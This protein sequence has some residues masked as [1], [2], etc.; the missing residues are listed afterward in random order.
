M[1]CGFILDNYAVEVAE[2]L[3]DKVEEFAEGDKWFSINVD[4]DFYIFID[5]SI[6]VEE[7]VDKIMP[8]IASLSKQLMSK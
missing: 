1:K 5:R 6:Y 3:D 8:I 2:L 7:N 4:R